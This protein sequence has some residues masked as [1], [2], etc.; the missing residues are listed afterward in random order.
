[1]ADDQYTWTD[2]CCVS[3]VA[4]C[5]TDVLNDCLMHLKYDKSGG[6]GGLPLLASLW[7]DHIINDIQWLRSDT[8]SWQDG[9]VYQA[10][11]D[12]LV[13]EYNASSTA[14][15][16]EGGITFKRSL[17]GFKIADVTQEQ[18]ILDKYNSTS[19][20]WYYI[21]DVT[22]KRF[23][24]PRTKYGFKGLR[25]SVGGDIAESLPNIKGSVYLGTTTTSS[26]G[27]ISVDKVA[28]HGSTSG[29]S[30][31]RATFNASDYNT[32]YQDNAPVQERGTQMY[33]YFYVGEYTQTAI[34]QT[35]GITSE[36]LN[37]KLDTPP[38]YPVEISDKSLMPSWYVVYN[39]GWCEQ[40]GYS[41]KWISSATVTISFL[42]SFLN[43][44][45]FVILN[46]T[47][48][49]QAPNVTQRTTT[50]FTKSGNQGSDCWYASGYIK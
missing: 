23:K 40:G 44:E 1:M 8:F 42:K 34:E 16:T 37:N 15:D 18:T 25:D 11:Y 10:V 29:T 45:Y 6:G 30:T 26:T 33:L 12:K 14:D 7:S 27:A 48:G 21:L 32:A 17:N 43:T 22:N 38:R 50:S 49:T 36:Q 39:D 2:N 19:I 13:E 31:D 5:N 3:G 46:A 4:P 41:S 47:Q 35:A 24:L 9:N 20:A 28:G